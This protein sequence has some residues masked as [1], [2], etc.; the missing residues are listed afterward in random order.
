VASRAF[1]C[2][3]VRS[4]SRIAFMAWRSGTR[5]LWQPSGWAGLGGSS[6]SIRSHS[7]S[8]IRHPS[9]RLTRPIDASL[10]SNCSD[11]RGF[12]L[13]YITPTGLGSKD[14]K[15]LL[16]PL[17]KLR[18]RELMHLRRRVR[19]VR[20]DLEAIEVAHDEQRRVL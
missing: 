14:A 16:W 19:E 15:G 4:T 9:S 13:G 17:E 5:G 3:P 20:V 8:G 7:Q 18:E 6:G 1:H 10:L 2:I 11:S 12:A